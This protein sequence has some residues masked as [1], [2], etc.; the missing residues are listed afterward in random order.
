MTGQDDAAKAPEAGIYVGDSPNA[1]A[2]VWKN[3]SYGNVFG[4]FIRDAAHGKVLNNKTFSNCVGIVFLNTD[5]ADVPPGQTPGPSVDVK[6]WL[7]QGNNVTANNKECAGG[8]EEPPFSGIGIG[9]VSAIDV[10]LIDN[11]VFGNK[12]AGPPA[13]PFPSAGILIVSDAFQ[14]TTGAKVGFNTAFGNATDLFWDEAR[15]RVRSSSRTTASPAARRAL[16]RPGLQRRRRRQRGRRPW[17]RRWPQRHHTATSH[18]KKNKKH[19]QHEA[20]EA[21]EAPHDD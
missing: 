3:V 20:Q 21:Q 16:R 4:L 11:G 12:A 6:D 19:K 10:R 2:T 13:G 8:G 9:V 18:H 7:A 14:A 1:N 5:E 15:A 17:R